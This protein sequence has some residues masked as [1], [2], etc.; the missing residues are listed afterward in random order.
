MGEVAIPLLNRSSFTI[1][2][3]TELTEGKVI[4]TLKILY[5]F[6]RM[7]ALFLHHFTVRSL[8]I[9]KKKGG[10]MG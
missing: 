8:L 7:A 6:E 4:Q 5:M 2:L 1:T 9:E 3:G 10:G